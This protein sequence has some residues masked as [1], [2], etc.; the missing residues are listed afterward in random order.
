MAWSTR[1]GLWSLR[2]GHAECSCTSFRPACVASRRPST[3]VARA[4]DDGAA[5]GADGGCAAAAAAAAAAVAAA[6]AAPPAAVRQ[7]GC[8]GRQH[9][10]RTTASTNLDARSRIAREMPQP[11]RPF[12]CAG[13]EKRTRRR[14]AHA[15]QEHGR[16]RR[17][18]PLHLGATGCVPQAYGF[19]RD[20][21][22]QPTVGR[23][24]HALHDICVAV[25]GAEQV[26]FVQRPQL[27]RLVLHGDRKQPPCMRQSKRAGQAAMHARA[28]ITTNDRR[29][30]LREVHVVHTPIHVDVHQHAVSHPDAPTPSP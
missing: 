3:N 18:A 26:A 5:I 8:G 24:T 19:P 15:P 20:G 17:L 21:R 30:V 23:Q 25:Q 13:D 11:H 22:E 12:V 27:D 2:S 14:E 7:D 10:T 4:A 1:A 29:T 6:L 28:V 9:R 16:E